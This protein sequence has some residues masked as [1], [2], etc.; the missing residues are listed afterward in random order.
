MTLMNRALSLLLASVLVFLLAATALPQEDEIL[1]WTCGM[2][3][4]VNAEEPGKCPICNMDLVPVMR[5]TETVPG[6]EKGIELTIGP[7][8][9]RL[10]RIRTA[11]VTRMMLVKKIRAPGELAYDETRS[12]VMSSR[13]SGWIE[14]L[15]ADYTGV[16]IGEGEPLAE[17]YSPELVTAQKEYLLARGTALEKGAGEKLLLLGITPA[18]VDELERRS[19]VKTVLPLLAEIGGTVVHRYVTDGDF[20][21][22]GQ[23]LFLVSDLSRLWV[24]ADL[25]ENNLHL[26]EIGQMASI[27]S[28]ALPGEEILAKVAFIEPSLDRKTRSAKV[29]LDVDNSDRLLK[30]GIRVDVA[31]RIP[32]SSN[33]GVSDTHMGHGEHGGGTGH[34]GVLAVPRSAIIDTGTRSIA[35]VE[36]APGRYQLRKVRLGA[37]AGGYYVVL[38]GLEEGERVV[39][40]GGFLLDSQT[41]LTGEAEE[42]YGGALGKDSGKTDPQPRH[43]H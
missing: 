43:I 20:V 32:L 4:S 12:A 7:D 38:A 23:A 31:F 11:E 33:S 41:Q 13:V 25:F 10:A 1:Y 14:R 24:Y 37:S 40:K 3:P 17:I 9:A 42:I 16:E 22:K 29:R 15:H 18:Q 21:K 34:G 5:E 35:F 39:E 2:H 26:V 28:D 36:I 8:A 30:P 6:E 27:T 19:D